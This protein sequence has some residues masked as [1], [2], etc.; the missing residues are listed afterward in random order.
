MAVDYLQKILTA[1]VYDVAIESPL[2]LAPT[3][4]RRLGNRVLLKREDQQPVF[5]FKLRGAYNKMAHL[6]PRERARGV[7]AASA[8]NHAQGV[9]LAAQKLGCAATIVM[10][11]TT[12]HIKVAAVEARGAKVVL[13]GDSYADAYAHALALQK[14]SRRRVRASLRRSGRDRRA[15]HDRHGDPAPVPGADRRDLRRR[16]RR[17]AHRAAS[18]P[19]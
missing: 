12:P 11:V 7:I 2:E 6:P 19:T 15:G 17:R 9:A 18:R 10:P 14:R 5:S 1:R 13:H 3:L 16:R 4:S 8:G